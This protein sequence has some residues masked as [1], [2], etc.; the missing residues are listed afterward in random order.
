MPG[1][2]SSVLAYSVQPQGFSVAS[3]A[4]S[5]FDAVPEVGKG[6]ACERL[7]L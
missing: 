3:I 4:D 5:P 2:P 7:T 1:F 6:D